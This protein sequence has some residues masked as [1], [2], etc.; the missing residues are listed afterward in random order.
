MNRVE[1]KGSKFTRNTI[2][3]TK[4]TTSTLPHG[5]VGR[6]VNSFVGVSHPDAIEWQRDFRNNLYANSAK[7]KN[8][9][10]LLES[11]KGQVYLACLKEIDQ[12]YIHAFRLPDYRRIIPLTDNLPEEQQPLVGKNI[13]PPEW[14]P[15]RS[16]HKL[17]RAFNGKKQKAKDNI[18]LRAD[19]Y[20]VT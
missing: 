5:D 8:M 10:L 9:E 3:F 17:R 20:M 18:F 15:V 16:I 4:M 2:T 11:I 14:Y 12:K 19:G 13:L 7:N 1:V 6:I